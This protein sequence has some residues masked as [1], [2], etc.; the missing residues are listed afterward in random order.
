MARP[1]VP[2]NRR[3]G[4]PLRTPAA[5]ESATT[6]DCFHTSTLSGAGARCKKRLGV[7]QSIRRSHFSHLLTGHF[8]RDTMTKEGVFPALFPEGITKSF[9]HFPLFF[10][11]D[12]GFFHK[13][14]IDIVVIWRWRG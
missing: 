9:P 5:A 7:E 2:K 12:K 3:R 4:Q 10:P 14:T 8:S 6:L 1:K 11:Q 13:R